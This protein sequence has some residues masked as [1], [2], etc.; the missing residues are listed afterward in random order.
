MFA[1]IVTDQRVA[2]KKLPRG[3]DGKERRAAFYGDPS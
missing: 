3:R 2:N 1:T